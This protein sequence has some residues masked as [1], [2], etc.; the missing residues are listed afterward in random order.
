MQ[1]FPHRSYSGCMVREA[2]V[3]FV[4]GFPVCAPVVPGGFRNMCRF[5]DCDGEM[6]LHIPLHVKNICC[7]CQGIVCV[8]V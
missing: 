4:F 2:H 7:M 1:S 5:H 6:M 3:L 8:V